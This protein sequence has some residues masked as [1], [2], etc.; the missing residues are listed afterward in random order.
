MFETTTYTTSVVYAALMAAADLADAASDP[1]HAVAW[2]SAANDIQDAAHR[3]LFNKDRQAF[4]KGVRTQLDGTVW[5]DETIDMSSVFGA[6]M[7]GLFPVDG[8]EVS[9][10][11]ATLERVFDF[12]PGVRGLPRYENDNYYRVSNDTPG[13]WWNIT[14]LWMAQYYSE[15]NQSE[16]TAKILEWVAARAIAP[17]GILS[18]Q[19]SPIDMTPLSVAPLT[20]S[21]AEY[22]ATLLD[23]IS[24]KPS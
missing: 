19:L 24:E 11:V 6:F 12:T 1:D 15:I 4:Y 22:V 7:F 9:A 16:K 2:R 13:N 23:T 14:T 5:H 8:P 10:A 3:Q 21:H 18:E 17:T 20:W